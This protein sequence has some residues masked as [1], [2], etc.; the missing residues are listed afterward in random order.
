VF[1]A[2]TGLALTM[3]EYEKMGHR[4]YTLWRVLT[5]RIMN[6]RKAGTGANM[7]TNFD[8]APS[9]AFDPANAVSAW[10]TL[11]AD[12]WE[13]AKDMMYEVFGYDVSTGMPTAAKLEELGLGDLIAT[14]RAEGV[15]P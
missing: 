7:R 10:G 8:T 14:L 9:W 11:K 1:N 4:M 5:A 2:V 15:I 13:L 6:A 12:D 3:A